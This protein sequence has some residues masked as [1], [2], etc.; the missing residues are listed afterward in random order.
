LNLT[1]L[2]PAVR[3]QASLRRFPMVNLPMR[4]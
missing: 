1:W 3:D 4:V 2:E